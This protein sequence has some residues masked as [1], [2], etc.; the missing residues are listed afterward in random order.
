ML[1]L[2]LLLLQSFEPA[3]SPSMCSSLPPPTQTRPHVHTPPQV[4]N[5]HLALDDVEFDAHRR[6]RREDV[7]EEDYA[8]GLER[9]PRL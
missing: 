5:P 9:A 7:G 8:V 1:L 3:A 2:L 4:W 6:Q